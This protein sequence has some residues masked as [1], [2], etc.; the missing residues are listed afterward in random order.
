MQ[1]LKLQ[2]KFA[3]IFTFGV[4]GILGASLVY[5]DKDVSDQVESTANALVS[6]QHSNQV[7]Q[8]G[9]TPLNQASGNQVTGNGNPVSS[10]PLTDRQ[11]AVVN[12]SQ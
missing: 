1:R 9:I 10:N 6:E 7:D 11:T 5:N 4:L 2:E 8:S 12:S 3:V